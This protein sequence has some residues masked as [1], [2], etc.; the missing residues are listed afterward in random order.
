MPFLIM[1]ALDIPI[2]GMHKLLYA[3]NIIFC[4]LTYLDT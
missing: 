4:L 2:H 1:V 3:H